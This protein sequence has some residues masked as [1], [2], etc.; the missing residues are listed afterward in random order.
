MF[1]GLGQVVLSLVEVI[2]SSPGSPSP[3]TIFLRVTFESR[4]HVEILC[5]ERES[6]G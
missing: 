6:M 1:T 5:M 4:L 2:A 3:H